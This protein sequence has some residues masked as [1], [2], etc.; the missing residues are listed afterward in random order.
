[1]IVNVRFFSLVFLILATSYLFGQEKVTLNIDGSVF[2]VTIPNN[3][4]DLRQA[5]LSAVKSYLEER[6]SRIKLSALFE[7]EAKKT[8]E[9]AQTIETLRNSLL[10]TQKLLDESMALLKNLSEKESL[11][12]FLFYPSLGISYPLGAHLALSFRYSEWFLGGIFGFGVVFPSTFYF[13]F[14]FSFFVPL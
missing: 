6:S 4:A 3:L 9:Q 11:G 2:T 10:E 8:L 12:S 7:S 14:G 13:L 5:Y 1:M